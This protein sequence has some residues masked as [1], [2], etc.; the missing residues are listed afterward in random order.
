MS[1][2]ENRNQANLLLLC[3]FHSAVIDAEEESYP[4]E[5]LRDWKLAAEEGTGSSLAQEEIEAILKLMVTE[6]IV[7]NADVIKLGGENAGGGGAIGFGA[8]GGAGGNQYHLNLVSGDLD[9]GA[10][11]LT[12]DDETVEDPNLPVFGSGFSTGVDGQPGG[13]TALWTSDGVIAAVGGGGG[14]LVGAGQR[15]QS[16]AIHV[17]AFLLGRYVE[18]QNGLG[19]IVSGGINEYCLASLPETL[20]LAGMLVIQAGDVPPGE[21]T[22]YALGIGPAGALCGRTSFPLTVEKRGNV[23]SIVR[24]VTLI[25]EVQ[26]Y[27]VY[28]LDVR[29]DVASLASI[30]LYVAPSRQ[31]DDAASE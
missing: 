6:E 25:I 12:P 15:M 29:S 10:P 19:T 31:T 2:D 26:Q 3:R 9:R 7:L 17:S 11:P 5:I 14:V 22:I 18:I 8:R 4:A 21:Y 20:T 13:T 16:E 30:P 28:N 1:E 27:G 23:L 24:Y